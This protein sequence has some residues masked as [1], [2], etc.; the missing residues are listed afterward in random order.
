[1]ERSRHRRSSPLAPFARGF[2]TLGFLV[3]LIAAGW[4]YIRFIDS[5]IPPVEESF[6]YTPIDERVS[7][8][9]DDTGSRR[10]STW[11][12]APGA[13]PW[14]MDAAPEAAAPQRPQGTAS[15]QTPA[16]P[17]SPAA[18]PGAPTMSTA[19]PAAAGA[20]TPRSA[21]P[22]SLTPSASRD[23]VPLAVR[24]LD[25]RERAELEESVRRVL[26]RYG[27]DPARPDPDAVAARIAA[28]NAILDVAA[29]M[30]LT[31]ADVQWLAR[32]YV[33]TLPPAAT[34]APAPLAPVP[35]A[36]RPLTPTTP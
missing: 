10:A 28:D 9:H 13:E 26:Q 35:L 7:S 30:G 16:S 23:R 36:P 21:S 27:H 14:G 32:E 31:S 15:T 19:I 33:A 20:T 4:L 6:A 22:G 8:R 18:R 17:P 11:P 24:T 5:P 34:T 29:T 12:M 3:L 25:S 1:M 2:E